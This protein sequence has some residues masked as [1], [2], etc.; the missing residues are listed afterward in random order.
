MHVLPH[1]CCT[2]QQTCREKSAPNQSDTSTQA[3]RICLDEGLRHRLLRRVLAVPVLRRAVGWNG[4]GVS[5]PSGV[6]TGWVW[7]GGGQHSRAAV[8]VGKRSKP[9]TCAGRQEGLWGARADCPAMRASKVEMQLS[10][11]SPRTSAGWSAATLRWRSRHGR[12]TPQHIP[13][14]AWDGTRSS[15]RGAGWLGCKW[16]S[17]GYWAPA[18]LCFWQ[19]RLLLPT[20][21]RARA[22]EKSD[23]AMDNSQ[24]Q[25]LD[26]T[27]RA[28]AGSHLGHARIHGAIHH[29]QR[30]P[31][32]VLL[33]AARP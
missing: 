31:I 23:A 9:G 26:N 16:W 18:V 32:L 20:P 33:A 2:Q 21:G 15:W 29:L 11:P 10:P 30:K 19:A 6:A 17:C 5:A 7:V 27:G 8:A 22:S 3:H 13:A 24:S 1:Q 14:G 4:S 12:Q 25:L 28:P